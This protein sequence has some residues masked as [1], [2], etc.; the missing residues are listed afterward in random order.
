MKVD[1]MMKVHLPL[2]TVTLHLCKIT[3][4]TITYVIDDSEESIYSSYFNLILPERK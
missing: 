2:Y 4:L 1:D 3:V